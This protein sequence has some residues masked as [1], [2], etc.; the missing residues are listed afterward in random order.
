MCEI[1]F[2]A[3]LAGIPCKIKISNLHRVE[4]SYKYNSDSDWDYYGYTDY[5]Y[6]VL[7]RNGRLALWLARKVSVLDIE[8][9]IDDYLRKN[10]D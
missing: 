4:G 5:D 6:E 1:L 10:Y 2:E 7:D 3:R 9:V 8:S